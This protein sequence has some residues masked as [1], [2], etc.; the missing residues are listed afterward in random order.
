M[1]R[2]FRKHLFSSG[3]V[4]DKFKPFPIALFFCVM[5]SALC[6]SSGTSDGAMDLADEPMLAQTKPA[7]AN[8]MIV[9]D[10][11][12]S[13]TFEVLVA[14]YYDGRYP[15]PDEGTTDGYCYIYDYLGDNAY[16][17]AI[18]YMGS[19][20]RKYWKSQYYGVNVMYYNPGSTYDPWPDY[21]GQSFSDADRDRPLPHP[22]KTGTTALNLDAESYR[23]Q[24]RRPQ[25]GRQTRALFRGR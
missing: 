18:R 12:G 16:T 13:M 4:S 22:L 10:D 1:M 25:S 2:H 6:L 9:L 19:E 21:P 5:L 14:G 7:P 23:C 15:N 17:D 24:R 11:S 8:I 3:N 20:G